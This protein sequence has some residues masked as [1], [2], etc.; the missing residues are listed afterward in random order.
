MK[1]VSSRIKFG[2]L[3]AL[4]F[5]LVF[6]IDNVAL[7][8]ADELAQIGQESGFG[9]ADLV[10]IIGT[11]IKIGLGLL[12]IIFL[13]LVIYSGFLWMTAGGDDGQVTRAKQIL[14]NGVVGM[15]IVLFS[16]AITSF[17]INAILGLPG[18]SNDDGPNGTVTIPAFSGSLGAGALRDHYPQRDQT[19]VARNANITVTFREQMAIDSFILN[20]EDNG[21]PLDLSDD[22]AA[23]LVNAGNIKIFRSA[24]GEA[25]ALTNVE[26]FFTD[27]LRTFVFNP[28]DYLGSAT[29]DVSYTVVL[30][31][32]IRNA[33][34]DKV[35]VG[36][37]SDGYEWSFATGVTLDLTPPEVVS[38]VPAAEGIFAKNII[39]QV[40]FNEPVDPTSAS[41]VRL[42]NSGFSNLEI[43][44]NGVVT[45]GTYRISNGYKT[46]TFESSTSCGLNSCGE[47]IYC[48]PGGQLVSSYVRSASLSS[49]PPQA[50]GFPYDGVVDMAANSLDGN[51]DGQAG[52]DFTWKFTTTNEIYLLGSSIQSIAPDILGENVDLDQSIELVF[53]DVLMSSTVNA[54]NIALTNKEITS[55]SSHEQWYRF[56]ADTLTADGTEVTSPNMTPAKTRVTVPHGVFLE[57]VDGKTYMYG[58]EVSERVKNQY[59]NCYLPAAGPNA[60]GGTCAVTASNPYCCNGVAQASA[61][62]LF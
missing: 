51:A 58:V 45:P 21:T 55:G 43:T 62:A 34:G 5:T 40:T 3:L 35:F 39:V 1:F 32:N 54:D 20:Y 7:A 31:N 24:D 33:A 11:I 14:I 57:S 15:V 52:D 30:D 37:N 48:L 12:G 49:A 27:D 36:Q 22:V 10:T 38:V 53:S 50:A 41:G 42:A 44:G 9:S 17:V 56:D 18:M 26:V 29:G 19:D 8:Q 60:A 59:Q 61:C 23:T 16:Y 47:V 4:A 25:G 13:V 2:F 28:T 46:V 6:G